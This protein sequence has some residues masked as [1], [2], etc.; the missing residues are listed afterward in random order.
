MNLF[1]ARQRHLVLKDVSRLLR[2]GAVAWLATLAAEPAHAELTISGLDEEQEQNATGYLSLATMPCDERPHRVRY[3]FEAAPEEV[4]E[5]L[6]PLGYY[7]P[8]IDSHLRFDTEC[9]QAE[10]AVD[11]GEPVR[12]RELDLQL[13]GPGA[14][15]SSL[16]LIANRLRSPISQK[17]PGLLEPGRI[18]RHDS[19]ETA[20]SALRSGALSLGYF[21]GRLVRNDAMVDPAVHAADV[22]LHFE[23]GV[24]YRIGELSFEGSK[25]RPEFL[26]A[27]SELQPGDLYSTKAVAT[28]QSGLTESGYFDRVTVTP[29]PSDGVAELAVNLTPG[30]RHVADFASA[31]AQMSVPP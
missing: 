4:A 3:A 17:E 23:T 28:L 31:S 29:R 6:A 13:L 20:K 9:W 25:L 22:H 10:F 19:Y 30:D 15:E 27:F 1:R 5:S 11:A 12:I 21:D 7:A 24:R 26:K 8:T 18:F 16:Q 14:E 2:T